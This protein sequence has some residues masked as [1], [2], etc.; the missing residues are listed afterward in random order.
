MNEIEAAKAKRAIQFLA[1]HNVT[2]RELV[3]AYIKAVERTSKSKVET[4]DRLGINV[5]TLW[6]WKNGQSKP[7][8]G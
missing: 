4:A 6:R 2:I 1:H 3:A 7:M 5:S 8:G